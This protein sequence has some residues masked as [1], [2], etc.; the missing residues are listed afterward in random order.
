MVVGFKNQP[1]KGE[2]MTKISEEYIKT[3]GERYV[4]RTPYGYYNGS[5]KPY[6]SNWEGAKCYKSYSSAY[7]I[8]KKQQV[9]EFDIVSYSN[10]SN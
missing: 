3:F 1:T 7:G 6:C 9:P 4:I 8:A 10:L 5:V 2:Q